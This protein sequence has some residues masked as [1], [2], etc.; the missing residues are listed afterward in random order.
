MN[1]LVGAVYVHIPFCRSKCYYCDFASSAGLEDLYQDYVDAL[2]LQA[3]DYWDVFLDLAYA[4]RF[5]K[6]AYI[7]G[8][9][10]TVLAPAQLI[11]VVEHCLPFALRAP[12]I[13]ISIE[14]N[15]GTVDADR[16]RVLRMM[17]VNRISLGVQ[18][19][20]DRLLRLIGRIHTGAEAAE[21]FELCRRMGFDNI[22]LDFIYGLPEQ[23]VDDLER[24]LKQAVSLKPEHISLYALSLEDHTRLSDMIRMGVFAVAD[25]DLL[26]D[27]SEAAD[28]ILTEAGYGLYEISNWALPG[29]ECSHNLVYWHNE[30]YIGFGAAAHSHL[31]TEFDR[32]RFSNFSDPKT[33]I[34]Q[35]QG[36]NDVIESKET[37]DRA[38][39]MM[40]TVIL[41]LRLKN[42]VRLSDFRR[43]YGVSLEDVYSEIISELVDLK[44]LT[45][46]QEAI[47][48]T[49]RGTAIGNEVFARFL[50]NA[51]PNLANSLT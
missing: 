13:E 22:N 25:D 23:S 33:F 24:S 18:S 16:L 4:Q 19:F 30:D 8:G 2:A 34:S 32:Q 31:T 26:G 27:M 41:G 15:P 38:I 37:I 42:G 51:A 17:G 21:A 7:G 39:D 48:L 35:I 1:N 14:A 45:I 6:S 50:P 5:I 20:D 47:K 36:G 9:T 44:L 40:E 10:P 28:L 29:Y 11:K 3:D 46:D 12:D 49:L 43:R